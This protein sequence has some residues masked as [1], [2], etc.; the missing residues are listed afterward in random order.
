MKERSR[1]LSKHIPISEFA[2]NLIINKNGNVTA[3]FRLF[4]PELYTVTQEQNGKIQ[5]MI[6]GL[7][8]ILD[9][10]VRL[11]FQNVYYHDRYNAEVQYGDSIAI[12]HNKLYFEDRLLLR[13]YCNLY[14]VFPFH[15]LTE[16][17]RDTLYRPIDYFIRRVPVIEPARFKD[18]AEQLNQ[19]KHFIEGASSVGIIRMGDDDLKVEFAKTYNLELENDD[20]VPDHVGYN[21]VTFEGKVGSRKF[22]IL[23]LLQD[24]ETLRDFDESMLI[25]GESISEE[26]DYLANRSLL[27]S[28][29]FPIGAG[30]PI[31]HV[32]NTVIEINENEKVKREIAKRI[33]I[34]ERAAKIIGSVRKRVEDLEDFAEGLNDTY[35]RVCKMHVNVVITDD[36]PER[37]TR[38][39]GIVINAFQN[40][41]GA[42]VAV[43]NNNTLFYH[44]C[45]LPGNCYSIDQ[46]LF[47]TT[48][49]AACYVPAE[50][51]Y[52]NDRNG[53][54]FVD[55][56]GNPV[57]INIRNPK[58]TNSANGFIFGKTGWGKTHLIQNLLDNALSNGEEVVLINTK[59]DYEK[60][61]EINGGVY[62]SA[63]QMGG[64]NPF[65]CQQS[66]GKYEPLQEDYDMVL[67]IL[68]LIWKGESIDS[69]MSTQERAII[70]ESL[71]RYYEIVNEKKTTPIFNDWYDSLDGFEESIKEDKDYH[72]QHG[73]CF[74]DFSALKITLKEYYKGGPKESVLNGKNEIN[75]IG[76]RLTCFDLGAVTR[77]QL[78]FKLY[79]T[80]CFT[81]ATRKIFANSKAG[82]FTNVVVDECIDSMQGKGGYVIG[83]Y[84]RKNRSMGAS[85]MISTQDVKYLKSLPTLVQDSISSNAQIK[86][87][88][89]DLTEDSKEY[90]MK[91]MGFTPSDIKLN[92]SCD[93]DMSKPYREFVLKIGSKSRILRSQ[94]S[95]YTN[96]VYTTSKDEVNRLRELFDATESMQTAINIFIKEKYEQ[97]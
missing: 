51:H 12:R 72:N 94:V 28:Y 40:M 11:H 54:L 96:V 47:T 15:R 75:L 16:A 3:G 83:E 58:Y 71:V 41:S 79:L 88:L 27:T 45:N 62:I 9:S 4:L 2:D 65:I 33:S 92:E 14:V 84:F 22:K 29:L 77:N 43:E 61:I 35:N 36:D 55:P 19:L 34:Y 67:E 82:V 37:L 20:L 10:G 25:K 60:F 23:R 87:V 63:D 93:T 31:P 13:N 26:L 57:V 17:K 89:G 68:E 74:V 7:A 1:P 5:D 70:L 81:V 38:M 46:M 6:M 52:Y 49:R 66:N 50:S 95:N 73:D 32:V 59:D 30:L 90:F 80:Y 91:H 21:P 78:L 39:E 64:I 69:I 86:I 56:F 18:I 48:G 24:G 42:R 53:Y 44:Y 85:V 97:E 76:N 8:N